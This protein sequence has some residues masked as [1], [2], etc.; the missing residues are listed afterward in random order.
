MDYKSKVE[1]ALQKLSAE[2]LIQS[3][4]GESPLKEVECQSLSYIL[5][6]F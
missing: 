6:T 1:I 3:Q 4:E 2:I 5:K